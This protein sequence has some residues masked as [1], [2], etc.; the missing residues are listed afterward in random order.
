MLFFQLAPIGSLHVLFRSP[1]H[2]DGRSELTKAAFRAVQCGRRSPDLIGPST[3][4]LTIGPHHEITPCSGVHRH[5]TARR[6][7]YLHPGGAG[8]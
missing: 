1:L 7:T 5:S 2:S 8:L 4:S 6:V 3:A